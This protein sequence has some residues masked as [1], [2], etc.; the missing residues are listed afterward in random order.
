MASLIHALRDLITS[1]FEAITAIFTTA[2][3]LIAGTLHGILSFFIGVIDLAM[4]TIQGTLNTMGGVGKLIISKFDTAG[5]YALKEKMA[6]ERFSLGNFVVIAV[7]G[8]PVF[9]F[10]TY[11]RSQGRPVVVGNKK[12]N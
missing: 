2:Y 12:V 1:V 7:V 11:Q 9:L 10:L 3:D 5:T 6:D 4:D 8:V